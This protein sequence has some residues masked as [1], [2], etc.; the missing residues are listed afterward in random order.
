MNIAII[1]LAGAGQ[2]A[3]QKEPKQYIVSMKGEPL[4]VAT[5]KKILRSSLFDEFY[6]VIPHGDEK[7]VET[8]LAQKV[9]EP[10][11][12]RLLEGGDTRE[13]S[14]YNA[15]KEIAKNSA[16]PPSIVLIHDADR[17]YLSI[18][19]IKKLMEAAK[20]NE[21]VIPAIS[22]HDSLLSHE[23]KSLRYLDRKATYRVQTPQVFHFEKLYQAF[24]IKEKELSSFTDDGSI[25]LSVY[26]EKIKLIEGEEENI[27]ITTRDELDEWREKA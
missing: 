24:S 13:E 8:I 23:G 19:L 25:Y 3:H 27:K 4:F 22:S 1:L 9:L 15:L 14:V 20:D 26:R 7:K 12:Y 21:A 6:F 10:F 18:S 2:R 17:P 16:N 5:F 11:S